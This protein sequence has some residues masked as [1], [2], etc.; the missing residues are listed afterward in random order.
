MHW[1]NNHILY[2]QQRFKYVKEWESILKVEKEQES[3]PNNKT[4][5]GSL[6]NSEKVLIAEEMSNILKKCAK[7]WESALNQEVCLKLRKS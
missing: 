1:N 4:V 7:C 5:L 6:L 2:G 3:A